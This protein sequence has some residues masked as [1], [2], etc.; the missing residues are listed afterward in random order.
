VV[1][2]ADDLHAERLGS[3]GDLATD[4][5]EADEA[6]GFSEKLMTGDALP[7]SRAHK[8]GLLYEIAAERQQERKGM[9]R[10]GGVIHAGAE[11]D[12]DSEIGCR[13]EVDFIEADSVFG[14]DLE[15]RQGLLEDLA[16]NG[17]IAA[18]ESVKVAGEF[19]HSSFRERTAFANDFKSSVRQQIMMA[20]GGILK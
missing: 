17:V 9:F 8:I 10:D 11:S 2:E 4:A 12:R 20:A 3:D 1:A 6:D 15:A 13:R 5:T 14:H 7:I 19:E 18:K 16:R